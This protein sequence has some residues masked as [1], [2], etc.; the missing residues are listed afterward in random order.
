MAISFSYDNQTNGVADI[1]QE[2]GSA[3]TS[4]FYTD[5]R[6][7]LLTVSGS[8]KT[9]QRILRRLLTNPG[10]YIWHPDYGAG[11]PTYIGQPLSQELYE[12]ISALITSQILLED[13]VAK[14]PIPTID[15]SPTTNGLFC[16][17]VYFDSTENTTVTLSFNLSS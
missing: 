12:E 4:D 17:I 15:L 2:I 11:L 7:D 1:Y 13:S 5:N 8:E 10:S 6:G 14:S 16:N 9:K 3:I